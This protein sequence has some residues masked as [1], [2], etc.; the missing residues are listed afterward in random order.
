MEYTALD[1]D[2]NEIRLLTL[3]PNDE[4]GRVCCT[5]KHVSLI[6]PPEYVALS[7]CWGD[8]SITKEIM[9]DGVPVQVGSNLESALRLLVYY[10][11]RIWV[12]AIYINQQDMAERSQQLLWMGSIYRRAERVAAWIGEEASDSNLAVDFI[13]NFH[14]RPMEF[15][16]PMPQ[17]EAKYPLTA[18]SAL[19]HLLEQPYWRR[20]WVIREIALSRST[21]VH[22]GRLAFPRKSLALAVENLKDYVFFSH[23]KFRFV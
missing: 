16:R 15:G 21:T 4:A 7:Y 6:N 14:S 9:I 13:Q 19:V 5:L 2:V 18:Y 20:V 17:V 3:L 23:V 8:A 22:C 10:Y 1:T 12:D 11:L